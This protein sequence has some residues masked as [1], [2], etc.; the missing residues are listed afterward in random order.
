[1]SEL[2]AQLTRLSDIAE[3]LLNETSRLRRDVV[4]LSG[5][6]EPFEGEPHIADPVIERPPRRD[7]KDAIDVLYAAR[8]QIENAERDLAKIRSVAEGIDRDA[9]SREELKPWLKS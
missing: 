6:I 4:R 7:F 3:K 2:H 1:M 8:Q 5:R 9:I